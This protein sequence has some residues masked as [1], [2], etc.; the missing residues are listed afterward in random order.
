[1]SDT[2][3]GVKT[4]LGSIAPEWA[5]Q[6]QSALSEYVT[7]FGA[8]RHKLSKS[9]EAFII[10]DLIRRKFAATYPKLQEAGGKIGIF[11]KGNRFLIVV[12][13]G[14]F[15]IKLKKLD[16]LLLSSGIRTTAYKNFVGQQACLPGFVEPTNM[17]LGYQVQNE[18][19]LAKSK[20]FLVQ[21]NGAKSNSWEWELE[22]IV[23]AQPPLADIVPIS[24]KKRVT[25]KPATKKPAAPKRDKRGGGD[26][27]SRE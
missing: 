27:G 23:A 3:D 8:S 13:N 14:K 20:I 15:T 10:N 6:L 19:E 17:H 5:T 2:K 7:E 11:K 22:A 25:L 1:M 21:P 4:A 12:E 26:D 16:A 18:A 9:C 24:K